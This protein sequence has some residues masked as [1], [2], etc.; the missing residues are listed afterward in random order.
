MKRLLCIA[1][2]LFL[3]GLS[4][5]ADVAMGGP[6]STFRINQDGT[7][8]DLRWSGTN[9]WLQTS[10][11]LGEDAYWLNLSAPADIGSGVMV[12]LPVNQDQQYF[13]LVNSLL[14]PPPSPIILNAGQSVFFLDWGAVSN[15]NAYNVYYAA[16]PN[17][18]PDNYLGLPEG[19]AALGVTATS[20][21]VSNLNAG[22]LYYFIVTAIN[23]E[24]ESAPS[25]KVSDSFG[26]NADVSGSIYTEIP[27][28]GQAKD[29]FLPGVSVSMVNA[30]SQQS[31]PAIPTSGNGTFMIPSLPYGNYYLRWSAAGY[32]S[33]QSTQTVAIAT[34]DP[35]YL[36]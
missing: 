30:D 7:N 8:V 13:R 25:E 32:I 28:N 33:G 36:D 5:T 17:I 24:G 1:F 4:F 14:L 16:D 12:S 9:V 11:L 6:I 20:L 15:A 2:G 3:I 31:S 34:S 10:P 29:V 19:T 26:P 18:S 22:K 27:A 23:S 21:M 35:V